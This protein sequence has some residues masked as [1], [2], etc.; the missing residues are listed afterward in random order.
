MNKKILI[1]SIISVAILILVSFTSVVGYGS[2]ESNVKESPLFNIRSNRAINEE[3]KDFTCDYVGKGEEITISLPTY[4]SRNT[5][6]QKVIDVIGRMDDK[7]FNRFIVLVISRLN[8]DD[9]IKNVDTLEIMNVLHRLRAHPD[10]LKDYVIGG[11]NGNSEETIKYCT[12][13]DAGCTIGNWNLGCF[14]VKI[15]CVL[16]ILYLLA[17][18]VSRT[19][20][21]SYT[22]CP[23]VG[24]CGEVGLGYFKSLI[25]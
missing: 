21:V 23:L 7:T 2:V 1:G 10:E 14:V 8:Q 19:W 4:N 15:F 20:F 25:D 9:K 17:R 22:W 3:S 24:H 12:I 18:L 6:L 5:Q 11:N 16:V 13:G